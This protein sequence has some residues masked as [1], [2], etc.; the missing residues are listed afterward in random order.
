MRCLVV[1]ACLIALSA[2]A[3]HAQDYPV[4]L[5]ERPQVLP[6]GLVEIDG[7]LDH[8]QRR[9]LGVETLSAE[10]LELAGSVGLGGRWQIG[11][12]TS[13]RLH[14]DS[15]WSRTAGV[16]A[17][18]SALR[19]P[20]FDL[21]PSA[22]LPLSFHTGYDLVST[23]DLGLGLRWRLGDRVFVTAGRELMPI[24]LRPAV[25]WNAALDGGVGVQVTKALAVVARARLV[26]VTLVGQ[27]DRDETPVD[28][29]PAVLA[30]LWATE[31]IDTTLEL[32]T[33]AANPQDELRVALRVGVRP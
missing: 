18:W 13:V 1:A 5:I 3:A 32:A 23:L 29:L 16:G 28:R 8:Q 11:A 30:L 4:A 2:G 33:D 20:R 10:D 27:I 9:A 6:A 14:P 31:R 21:A 12:A 17:A 25:A 19:R 24:D 7:R 26:E 22:W 15:S